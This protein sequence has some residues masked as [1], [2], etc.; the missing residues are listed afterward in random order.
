MSK[1]RN[2]IIKGLKALKKECKRIPMDNC[3][4]TCPYKDICEE[5]CAGTPDEWD[6]KS[7]NESI[8]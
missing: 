7:L 4:N 1:K 5:V 2:K 3:P 6:L 8:K